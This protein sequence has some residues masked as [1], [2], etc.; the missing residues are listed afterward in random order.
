[1]AVEILNPKMAAHLCDEF[2]LV[3]QQICVAAKALGPD[4]LARPFI[5]PQGWRIVPGEPHISSQT[6]LSRLV[7]MAVP[8]WAATVSTPFTIAWTR[9]MPVSAVRSPAV[10]RWS[11]APFTFSIQLRLGFI[12]PGRTLEKS[13]RLIRL[14]AQISQR[15]IVRRVDIEIPAVFGE[16]PSSG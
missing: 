11:P 7:S 8:S 9:R 12:S 6:V 16:K 14:P 15:Q 13:G 1:M 5:K 2:K 10:R 4:A 3:P